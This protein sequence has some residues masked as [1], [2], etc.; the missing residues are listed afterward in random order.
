M[1]FSVPSVIQIPEEYRGR[2]QTYIKHRVLNQY[3]QSWAQKLASVARQFGRV[4]IWYVDCFSGPWES[5]LTNHEDTSIHIGLNA[6]QDAAAFWKIQGYQIDLGAIFVEKDDEAYARLQAYLISRKDQFQ[7]QIHALHGEFGSKVAEIERLIGNDPAFLFVDP[8]GW[9]GAA[10]KYI[11]PLAK[12]ER[13]DVVVNVMYDHINRF[14]GSNLD[15]VRKQLTEFFETEVSAD[16]S[17]EALFQLYRDQLKRVCGLK[18][19]ADLTVEDPCRDRTKFRLVLGAHHHRALELFRDVEKT[20]LG[21]ETPRIRAAAK[22]ADKFERTG[23]YSLLPPRL[24]NEDLYGNLHQ[25]ALVEVERRLPTI[26]AVRGPQ[27]FRTLANEF[28]QE[29]HLPVRDLGTLLGKWRSSGR[30]TV[31]GMRP[32]EKTL[33]DS[34]VILAFYEA[35]IVAVPPSQGNLFDALPGVGG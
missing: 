10:M 30:L 22:D 35:K 11:A 26:L 25:E 12:K 15:Y 5:G 1:A 27:T 31:D 7:I 6:I 16:L 33:K 29:L 14:K 19:A 18:Y 21:D 13:R 17:E 9:K 32:R 8:T 20:V 4:R 28:L 23:Q 34:H 3:I 24:P 2:E